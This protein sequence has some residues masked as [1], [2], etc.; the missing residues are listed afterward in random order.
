VVL[1]GGDDRLELGR[2]L[3]GRGLALVA[4][5]QAGEA[6]GVAERAAGEHDGGGAALVEGGQ[7]AVLVAEAAGED[8]GD[9]NAFGQLAGERVVGSAGVLLGGMA[10][11]EGDARDAGLAHQPPGQIDAASIAGVRPRP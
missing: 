8:H 1:G 6:P 10:G 7:D 11:V 2:D 5:Q 3:L 4:A 9:G